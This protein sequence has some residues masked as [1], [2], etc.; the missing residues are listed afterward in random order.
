MKK[1]VRLSDVAELAQTSVKTASRVMNGNERVAPETQKRVEDAVLQLGYRVNLIARSLRKGIDDVIGIVVPSIGDPFFA[2][3]IDEIEEVALE[4]GFQLTISSNHNETEQERRIISQ[5]EQR[6][7]SG[8]II[9]PNDADY[10]FLGNSNIPTV[11]FDRAPRNYSDD[12][13]LVDDILG[14]Q[15]AVEH[16]ISYG[17]KNIAFLSDSLDIPT[18]ALRYKGYVAAF[19]KHGL[20]INP[21]LIFTGGTSAKRAEE[22]VRRLI[23]E[24]PDVSAMFSTRSSLSIGAVKALHDM[25]RTDIAFVSFGDFEMSDVVEPKVTVIDHSPRD[26]GRLA[27]DRLMTKIDGVVNPAEHIFS[28]LTLISRGSGELPVSGVHSARTV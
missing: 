7:V 26:L 20:P 23:V 10:S 14:A 16:L 1:A 24:N 25:F 22:I 27:I 18:S 19:A 21:N 2:A 12:V 17:H 3:A 15:S 9:T 6:K 28:K 11:F 5:M 8:M 4:R 13:V